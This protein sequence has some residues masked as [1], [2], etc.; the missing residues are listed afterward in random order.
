[1][2]VMINV[3]AT[4]QNRA[5]REGDIIDVSR[6]RQPTRETAVDLA[7]RTI[8][9]KIVENHYPPGYQVLERQ[10]ADEVGV[11][12]T[13][14]REA[15]I[16]LQ[17]EGLVEVI[18]RQGMRVVPLSVEDMK[19]IYQVITSLEV[20]AVE[21]ATR[22]EMGD[23]QLSDLE[24]ALTSMDQA[25]KAADLETWAAAD[26]RFHEL[27]VKAS[28]NKRLIAMVGTLSV[29]LQRARLMTLRLRPVP[30]QSNQEHWEVFEAIRRGDWKTA[31]DVHRNHRL[32]T[33]KMLIDL[34]SYYRLNHL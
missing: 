32:R 1:M 31:R 6:I 20:T 21:L 18:P 10:L 13:P 12:R 24:S 2:R 17:E 15:L 8:K 30:K 19:E 7:Y 11:S 5:T 28:G 25:L 4:T 9:G 22:K 3:V 34:L 29:Q 16:R 33:S 23:Q 27:L 14:I 26:D